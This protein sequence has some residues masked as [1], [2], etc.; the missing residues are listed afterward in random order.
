MVSFLRDRVYTYRLLKANH[1]KNERESVRD[2]MINHGTAPMRDVLPTMTLKTLDG[3]T[4]DPPAGHQRQADALG[5]CRAVC[6][7]RC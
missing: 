1:I 2:Y 6:R 3:R 7:T 4:P 5:V